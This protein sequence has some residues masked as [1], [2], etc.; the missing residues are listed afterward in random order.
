MKR[1]TP[2]YRRLVSILFLLPALTGCYAPAY[3]PYD[4]VYGENRSYNRGYANLPYGQNYPNR[5]GQQGYYGQ[6]NYGQ[7]YRSH[8]D[9]DDGDD[10]NYR[11]RRYEQN[12]QQQGYRYGGYYGQ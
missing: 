10:D 1:K 12:R 8:H 9:D 4:T 5:S 2:K 11:E 7:G 6:D 3:Y